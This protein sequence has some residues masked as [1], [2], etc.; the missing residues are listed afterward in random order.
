[1]TF[2]EEVEE[3]HSKSVKYFKLFYEENYNQTLTIEAFYK[4]SFEFQ[5]GLFIQ[6]FNS[7]NTDVDMY[8]NELEALKDSIEEAFSTYEEYLFLDS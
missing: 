7:I 1:M 8:S 3:K 4:L 2:L 6:F 5:L